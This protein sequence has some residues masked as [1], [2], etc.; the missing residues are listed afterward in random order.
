MGIT[1]A[2]AAP[3][4]TGKNG[5]GRRRNRR[6][7]TQ[8]GNATKDTSKTLDLICRNEEVPDVA[9]VPLEPPLLDNQLFLSK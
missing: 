2:T 4:L 3:K 9:N 8:L 1:A 5:E 7:E 6:E